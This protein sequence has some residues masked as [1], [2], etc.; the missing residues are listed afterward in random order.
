MPLPSTEVAPPAPKR[1]GVGPGHG[2]DLREQRG[3]G[4]SD[5]GGDAEVVAD[6]ARRVRHEELAVLVGVVASAL[7]TVTL[8]PATV[9]LLALEESPYQ[10]SVP[11]SVE[12]FWSEPE[13]TEI[14]SKPL[15]N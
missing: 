10:C 3:H 4:V 8:L 1:S 9:A 2:R 13:I 14:P 15:K 12:W 7:R 6:V 11:A 5:E